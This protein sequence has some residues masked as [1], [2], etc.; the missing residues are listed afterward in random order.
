MTAVG[1]V[2]RGSWRPVARAVAG[3]LG[4]GLLL[5]L[6]GLAA[7]LVVVPKATGSV[8]L[9]VLTESMEPTLPAGTLLVVRPTPPDDIAAGDV[10]T[11]QAVSGEQVLV[12]HRVVAVARSSD[13]ASTFTTKGDANAE[14]D[15]PVSSAQVR[16]VVWYSVPAVGYVNQAVN[17]AR[18]WLVPTVA[19]ALIAWGAV[20][21]TR[22]V[23]A[24]VRRSS[25]QRRHGRRRSSSTDSTDG[26]DRRRHVGTARRSG[27]TRRLHGAA[28][29]RHQRGRGAR[30]AAPSG[31]R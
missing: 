21:V 20:L 7:V 15:A 12:S 17:G 6:A 4:V 11:Y 2:R 5:L 23:V 9:T 27:P 13:G 3:G 30:R 19:V 22:G 26:T 16:G 1:D 8:P 28:L 29:P 14:A 31:R 10:V 25:G 18:G 24:A